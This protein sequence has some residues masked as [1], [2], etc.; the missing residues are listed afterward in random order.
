VHFSAGGER[1]TFS[2]RPSDS[3]RSLAG[4]IPVAVHA[5]LRWFWR[6]ALEP[7]MHDGRVSRAGVDGAAEG[8]V[9]GSWRDIRR[10][11]VLG[12]WIGH[13]GLFLS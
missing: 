5:L 7:V 13:S 8:D 11:G 4:C 9:E 12:T 2:F 10:R 3:A 6:T 1:R